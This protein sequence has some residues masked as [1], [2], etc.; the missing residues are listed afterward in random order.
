MLKFQKMKKS[1]WENAPGHAWY[2]GPNRGAYCLLLPENQKKMEEYL[3]EAEKL[4]QNDPLILARIRMEKEAFNLY[5]VKVVEEARKN[6][7]ANRI[8]PALPADKSMKIDGVLD[9]PQW[10]KVG[11]VNNFISPYTGNKLAEET[12]L[13]VLYDKKYFYISIE[14]MNDKAW[15]KLLA[16]E[17]RN[18]VTAFFRLFC[19]RIICISPY[20]IIIA[21]GRYTT[22]Y[23]QY[24]IRVDICQ[25]KVN[26]IYSA[27]KNYLY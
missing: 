23:R 14:C 21:V 20:M 17:T 25:P 16:K 27:W 15:T 26:A 13:R 9:E 11:V 18:D 24:I 3:K 5:W 2:P 10:K 22:V 6:Q 1:L 12:S 8:I 4:A 19:L 7:A